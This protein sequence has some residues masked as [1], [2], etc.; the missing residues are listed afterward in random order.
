ML[1]FK[2][3][4]CCIEI[5]FIGD[6]GGCVFGL[7]L[8]DVGKMGCWMVVGIVLGFSFVDV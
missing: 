3:R 4:D 1:F 6:K 2:V 7:I 5:V 8:C